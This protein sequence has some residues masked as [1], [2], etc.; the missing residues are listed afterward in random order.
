MTPII[1]MTIDSISSSLLAI[2]TTFNSMIKIWD[3]NK[4]Y[5]T[6]HFKQIGSGSVNHLQFF[7]DFENSQVKA[8]IAACDDNSINIWTLND[9]VQNKIKKQKLD[10]NTTEHNISNF[11]SLIGHNANITGLIILNGQNKLLS[12]GR[13]KLL[14]LWDL[15]TYTSLKMFQAK[16]GFE[17]GMKQLPSLTSL[18]NNNFLFLCNFVSA[19]S[20]L[21]LRKWE[22]T[23]CQEDGDLG[24]KIYLD[25]RKL[26]CQTNY[27]LK[28][29]LE[30]SLI[31][32]QKSE[33]D[34]LEN[35]SDLTS[36]N[37][38]T[39]KYLTLGA[40]KLFV[41]NHQH[42]IFGV[43][44]DTLKNFTMY[45]GD[46]EEVTAVKFIAE[47]ADD[48]YP[49]L[50]VADNTPQPKIFTLPSFDSFVLYGHTENIMALSTFPKKSG[51]LVSASKD[52]TMK[53]WRLNPLRRRFKC[54]YTFI[55]HTNS[56][57]A[58]A[59]SA[60]LESDYVISASSD[61]TI[62]F[63]SLQFGQLKKKKDEQTNPDKSTEM[64][65]D[66]IIVKNVN[67]KYTIKAH[68]KDINCLCL[69][70]R[71][72]KYFATGSM[73]KT[74]KLWNTTDGKLVGIFKGHKRGVWDLA[75]SDI[76]QIL[77]TCSGDTT[78]KLWILSDFNCIRTLEGHTCAVL[79]L[80]FVT[81]ST[82]LLTSSS[83]G[84]MKLWTIETEN[85]VTFDAHEGKIWSFTT[86]KNESLMATGGGS[87]GKILIWKDVSQE[88]KKETN[89]IKETQIK[90]RQEISNLMK[91]K[92]Y[93]HR[94]FKLTIETEDKDTL[95]KAL[96]DMLLDPQNMVKLEKA[97]KKL[98]LGEIDSLFR[99][100]SQWNTNAKT[101]Y[102]AQIVLNTILKSIHP[103]VLV[104]L[105]NIISSIQSIVPYTDRHYDRINKL[106]QD[107]T[108]IEY[109]GKCIAL[110]PLLD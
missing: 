12:S 66:K 7:C 39:P 27:N 92:I 49:Y 81:Q 104:K 17:G 72:S 25:N 15:L 5:Y 18:N 76:H 65:D 37:A 88:E 70:P 86:N 71:N 99:F 80:Q 48:Q 85:C 57:T 4:G 102:P 68:D 38:L 64:S 100:S 58:L 103:D 11:H 82:Q 62:K 77:A 87:D 45:I 42:D 40:D 33:N 26:T 13:D 20:D 93:D 47:K 110:E 67:V 98:E 43:K 54:L 9:V 73:D 97:I 60:D 19:D 16:H 101:C 10:L 91:E 6:H 59:C 90:S 24:N 94:I 3:L 50:A 53:L 109:V 51:L 52:N 21:T 83:D 8:I 36:N 22:L 107:S 41:T 108:F 96:N 28:I 105:P 31:P 61:L 95:L 69:S 1:T 46:I 56:V 106:Y 44:C 74:A 23:A 79:H 34:I 84:L 2:G 35:D 78:I 75:F 63:W 29:T 89:L 32:L 14:I 55:G 30:N